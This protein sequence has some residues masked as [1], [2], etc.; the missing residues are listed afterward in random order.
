MNTVSVA[1]W[2]VFLLIVVYFALV[3][4]YC[5]RVASSVSVLQCTVSTFHPELL[6][7]RQPL[8]V[9]DF[10]QT[11]VYQKLAHTDTPD[12]LVVE[13][14][15]HSLRHVCPWLCAPQPIVRIPS[16]AQYTQTTAMVTLMVQTTGNTRVLL[17]HP[18]HMHNTPKYT[19][20]VL[21]EGSALFIPYKW[22][23][24]KPEASKTRT[25]LLTWKPWVRVCV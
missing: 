14:T 25:D 8:V 1:L 17:V 10:G 5:S 23:Y 2:L 16:T 24:A 3:I 9:T 12:N 6:D 15:Y 19:E 7:E 22:W 11:T 4:R 20:I 13:D 21:R 18:H